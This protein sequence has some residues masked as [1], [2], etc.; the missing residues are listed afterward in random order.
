MAQ[1]LTGQ[2]GVSMAA[3]DKKGDQPLHLACYG[4]HVN[5]AKWLVEMTHGEH[6]R[7]RD[8]YQ[9]TPLHATGRDMKAA[10]SVECTE[11]LIANLADLDA[12]DLNR[13]SPLHSAAKFRHVEVL[14]KF[15]SN[16]TGTR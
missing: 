7:A 1:W 6:V 11:L 12:V 5:T 13:E 4:G 2:E 10:G 8:K 3:T 15:S 9:Q 14:K 16:T